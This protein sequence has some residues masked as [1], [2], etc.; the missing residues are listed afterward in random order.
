M[1]KPKTTKPF[2][3]VIKPKIPVGSRKAFVEKMEN[4]KYPAK[5]KKAEGYKND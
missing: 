3:V 5:L 2:V 1:A 4:M